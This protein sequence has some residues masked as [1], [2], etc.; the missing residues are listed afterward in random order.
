MTTQSNNLNNSSKPKTFWGMILKFLWKLIPFIAVLLIIGIVIIPLGKKITAKKEALALQQSKEH[1][2]AKP[3]TNVVTLTVTPGIIKET[4]SLPGVAKPWISL[5]VVSQI[6]GIVIKKKIAEGRHVNKGDILAVIDKRDYQN[7]YDAAFASYESAVTTKKRLSALLKKN[8]VTKSNLDDA[9]ALLKTSKAALENAKL[10]L[11]RCLIRSPL[12]GVVNR[13]HIENGKF[14]KPGDPVVQVLQIDKLKIEVGIP[15]SDVDAV[16]KLKYF[17]ITI[18][19]LKGK[20]CKGE[21]HYL[22]KTS[23]SLARLY[24]LEIKVENIGGEILPDMFARVEIIKNQDP[25]GLAVPMYSLVQ[26]DNKVGLY[27]ENSGIIQFR[28]VKTGFQ[29]GWRTQITE[30]LN[31]GDRVVVVGHRIIEDGQ[32]VNVTKNI[33]NMKE[34]SQ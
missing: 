30:G 24:N 5:D 16:R 6:T 3:L 17:D 8:F 10:N 11:N 21:Y 18:D 26:L 34:I 25:N 13:V 23:S 14:L 33:Q 27:L 20:I 31:P 2:A 28:P 9:N 29:T 19:A 4:L 12:K 22:Y 7:A 15:E 32:E 1:A